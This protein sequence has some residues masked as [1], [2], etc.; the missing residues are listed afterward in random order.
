ML[1]TRHFE[2]QYGQIFCFVY[3]DNFPD[4]PLPYPRDID[5]EMDEFDEWLNIDD[6][7]QTMAMTTEEEIIAEIQHRGDNKEESDDD[8]DDD[9]PLPAPPSSREMTNALEVLKRGARYY[10]DNVR[11]FNIQYEYKKFNFKNY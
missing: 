9:E 10:I 5:L 7:V 4:K 1:P 2:H 11:K 6:N 8:D 3:D